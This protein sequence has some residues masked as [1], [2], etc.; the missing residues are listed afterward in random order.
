M[1]SLLGLSLR[2]YCWLNL[3]IWS[4]WCWIWRWF[5]FWFFWIIL[6]F[7]SSINDG[8]FSCRSNRSL[9]CSVS[10]RNLLIFSC[11]RNL[12]CNSGSWCLLRIGNNRGLFSRIWLILRLIL[13]WSN[14]SLRLTLIWLHSCSL[15][16]L[17][18]S[19]LRNLNFLINSCWL[20]PYYRI[21]FQRDILSRLR[22]A[23]LSL[24]WRSK[25][26]LIIIISVWIHFINFFS[27]LT[28]WL[29]L[30]ILRSIHSLLNV[31]SF[32]HIQPWNWRFWSLFLINYLLCRWGNGVF[33]LRF[34]FLSNLWV[35]WCGLL[36]WVLCSNGQRLFSRGHC[37]RRLGVGLRL[38]N[39]WLCLRLWLRNLRLCLRLWDLRL[40]LKLWGLCCGRL[41][42][43]YQ[44]LLWY[45]LLFYLFNRNISWWCIF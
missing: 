10:N 33:I 35:L 39:L 1:L 36:C 4:R 5:F 21:D 13:S 14:L 9:F 23:H 41:W 24:R 26:N 29:C 12:F 40:C 30:F 38:R 2:I 45:W 43:L 31:N 25:L 28:L 6:K 19:F 7:L 8:L 37:W 27:N 17:I 16:D 18:Q 34:I 42:L 44:R 32:L 22:S 3:W 11:Y 15:S 20:I